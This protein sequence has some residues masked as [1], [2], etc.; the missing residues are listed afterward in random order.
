VTGPLP[1]PSL[2]Q[3]H[4][5]KFLEDQLQNLINLAANQENQSPAARQKME[6][7]FRNYRR[8]HTKLM[9]AARRIED[10]DP[11]IEA[12]EL[13]HQPTLAQI[14]KKSAP[15]IAVAQE[16]APE[17]PTAKFDPL[18]AEDN[19]TALSE[20]IENSEPPTTLRNNLGPLGKAGVISY[21]PEVRLLQQVLSDFGFQVASSG[22]YDN[23]TIK[24]VRNFQLKARLTI[25]GIVDL[26]TRDLLN[27]RLQ[28]GL[29]NPEKTTAEPKT[30]VKA[31]PTEQNEVSSTQITQEL[32]QQNSGK[33]FSGAQVLLLQKTLLRQGFELELSGS[34][35]LRTFSAVRKFQAKHKL[36]VNGCVGPHEQALLNPLIQDMLVEEKCLQELRSQLQN[37]AEQ[38]TLDFDK[39][40]QKLTERWFQQLLKTILNASPQKEREQPTPLPPA[41]MQILQSELGTPGQQGIISQGPEV[42]LLQEILLSQGQ[43]LKISESFDLQTFTALRN[44]QASQGLAPTG[45]ADAATRNH[46][47]PFVLKRNAKIALQQQMREI[48]RQACADWQRSLTPELEEMIELTAKKT[49]NVL[50]APTDIL[51]QM[52]RASLPETMNADLAPAGRPGKVSKGE[53]VFLLQ[54]LLLQEGFEL[55]ET[56]LFDSA[57]ATAVRALQRRLKLPLTGEADAR[58]RTYFNQKSE[59][60]S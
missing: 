55:E 32:G 39:S 43:E 34:F 2:E 44:Y 49:T 4:E 48:W 31:T 8:L 15:K 26:R 37:Y 33:V 13:R 40:R 14:Q 36:P 6:H 20:P 46:L 59:T 58:I 22:E 24:A 18:A 53:E 42:I 35:E 21:G 29:K 56:G 30:D 47:N 23:P 9:E 16:I 11:L 1:I 41:P 17:E 19:Q 12:L 60:S 54:Y 7:L 38:Q 51:A 28:A 3:L 57:T 5:A 25:T 52:Q 27:R 50:H 45:T 10:P